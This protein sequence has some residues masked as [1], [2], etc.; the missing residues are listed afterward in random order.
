MCFV[1]IIFVS[2]SVYVCLT[3]VYQTFIKIENILDPVLV[4]TGFNIKLYIKE[5][6]YFMGWVATVEAAHFNFRQF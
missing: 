5:G 4:Q 2:F 1:L 6:S 3:D